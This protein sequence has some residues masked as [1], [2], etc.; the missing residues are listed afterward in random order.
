MAE[1]VTRL[2]DDADAGDPST[3]EQKTKLA[4]RV[5]PLLLLLFIVGDILGGGIYA[6]AGE[7]GAETG[8]AIW[9]G[10]LA[11]FILAALTAFAYAELVSKYPRA[12]GAALYVNRAFR[13][14]FFTF[15][16]AF[17]VMA[18]GIT[19]ASTLARAFG[20][21][22]LGGVRRRQDP[23]GGDRLPDRRRAD[24]H[25]RNRGVGAA[26]RG[27]HADR[28]RGTDPDRRDRRRR[29]RREQLGLRPQLR[30]QGG[31]DAVL[32]DP[33]RRRAGLLRA[34]RLR[35]LG[36]HRRGGPKSKPELSEDPLRRAADRRHHLPDR[37]AARLGRGR[38]RRARE[39][40]RSAGHRRRAGPARRR[41]EG[42]RRDHA[43]RALER[44]ADQHDHGLAD[45]LR[46]VG[47]GDRPGHLRPRPL[48][49]GGRRSRRSSSPRCSGSSS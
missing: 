43:L 17:A 47:G 37:H 32:R 9:T 41:P 40:R 2:P 31:R 22:A 49:A 33:L 20:S 18:S 10:F 44:R 19:S 4:R 45:R 39:H 8:G 14:P 34:D 35:G 1:A 15:M 26:E 24:Q 38:D 16:I 5:G 23:A 13:Q 46:D 11:A 7:V 27:A 25:A 30:V 28:G 6:L 12:A 29:A 42:V 3:G 21:D 36:Q 48:R